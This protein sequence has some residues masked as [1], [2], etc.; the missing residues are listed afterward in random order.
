MY[1]GSC[2]GITIGADLMALYVNVKQDH[3]AGFDPD[4]FP[5]TLE[6]LE[7]MGLKLNRFD[8]KGRLTRLGFLISDIGYLSHYFGGG[9]YVHPDGR[10]ELNTPQNL[11]A[12]QNIVD[13]RKKV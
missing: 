12:L 4:K 9:F 8:S 11:R 2:Y 5:K 6:E 1:K 13:Y 7:D 3:E 10:L